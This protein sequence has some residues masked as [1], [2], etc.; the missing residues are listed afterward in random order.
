MHPVR[1]MNSELEFSPSDFHGNMCSVP[2]DPSPITS[3]GLTSGMSRHGIIQWIY[4]LETFRARRYD[5]GCRGKIASP[6]HKDISFVAFIGAEAIMRMG[7]LSCGENTEEGQWQRLRDQHSSFILF[8]SELFPHDVRVVRCILSIIG[9]SLRT[10]GI[11]F[12]T[13]N[14]SSLEVKSV[15]YQIGKCSWYPL[16]R[17][18][19][20]SHDIKIY[21]HFPTDNLQYMVHS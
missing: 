21:L 7:V 13:L 19:D 18:A 4:S 12:L 9:A 5:V 2:R 11:G 17:I 1:D 3:R 6:P 14:Q 15:L 20:L 10:F 8:P 16:D